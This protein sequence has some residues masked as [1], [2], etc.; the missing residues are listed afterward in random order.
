MKEIIDSLINNFI[1]L[2]GREPKVLEFDQRTFKQFEEEMV[3]F[4]SVRAPSSDITKRVGKIKIKTYKGID[5]E[6]YCKFY[7]PGNEEM[8]IKLK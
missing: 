5:I 8:T 3:E 6:V 7:H 4:R 2:Y 1:T